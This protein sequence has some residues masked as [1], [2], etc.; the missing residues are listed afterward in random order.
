VTKN[1]TLAREFFKYLGHF[2]DDDLKVFVQHLLRKTPGR[3]YSYLKVTVH[4]TSKVYIFYYS[5]AEWVERRKKK[6]I[7]LQEFDA[8]DSTLEFTR[9]DGVV[10]NEKWKEWKKTH[11]VYVATWNVL[12]CIIPAAYFAKHLT[13]EGKVKRACEFQE[14]FPEVLHFLR[15]FLR[16]KNNF[17][18]SSG[19][20]KFRTLKR[21]SLEFGRDWTYELGKRLSFAVLD[22]RDTP[23]HSA[24]EDHVRNP[25]F[26]LFF[27]ALHSLKT[28]SILKPAMWL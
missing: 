19:S 14:K 4:K 3:S 9:A 20:A 5:A 7:V 21:D 22:L 13:N 18:V 2:T 10:N 12:L 28:P 25:H 15:N 11:A 27:T 16:L 6:M 8:L 24:P 23:G 26:S 17:S 1:F